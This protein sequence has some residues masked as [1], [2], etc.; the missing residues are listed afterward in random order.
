[1]KKRIFCAFLAVAMLLCLIPLSALVGASGSHV[2]HDDTTVIK[3]SVDRYADEAAMKAIWKTKNGGAD[4][5]AAVLSM[6][7][8]EENT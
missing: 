3:E 6:E 7:T 2:L 5:S 4:G 1:M 8:S